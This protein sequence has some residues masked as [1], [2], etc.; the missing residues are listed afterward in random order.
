MKTRLLAWAVAAVILSIAVSCLAQ[1]A[2]PKAADDPYKPVLDRMHAITTI[3]LPDWRVHDSNLPHGEDTNI[4][5]SGWETVRINDKWTSGSRWLRH[6]L[7]VPEQLNGYDLRGARLDLDL[8]LDSDDFIQVAVFVNG[9]MV[10][11]TDE[12]TQLPVTL[13]QNALPGQKFL[14]AV[15]V[16][17]NTIATKIMRAQVVVHA[18]ANRPDPETMRLEI[19]SARP[20][21]D[22]Y[23]EGKPTREQQLDAVVKAISLSA[24]D[25]SDQAA[26]DQSLRD[27]QSRLEALRP[28]IKQFGIRAS[29]NSHI[30]MAWLWPWTETVE[31]V[32]NTFSSVLQL[33]R[34]YPD[35]TFSMG[36]AQT[37][38]WMEEKYTALFREIQ[39]RVKEGRWEIVGG[40]W[41]EPDL[42]MPD[43]ESLVRQLLYGKRYF[44][45]K[46]GVD[47][48]IGWNPDSFGYSWQLPQIYK[49]SGIDTFVTQKLAWN[50]TNKFPYRLFWWQ[51]PDGSRVL[52]YFPH[53]YAN[54]IDPDRMANDLA[55][56]GPA[57]WK[58][59]PGANSLT[60]GKLE[61]MYLFGV[62]DHGGGPTRLDLDNA[63]RWSQPDVVYPQLR[64]GD[65][66]GFFKDLRQNED[67]LKIP[68]WND[69]IYF[70]YHRGV[71]TSQSETKRGNRKSE[72]L[73]LNAEKLAAIDTLFG[74]AY[75][76]S[77]F[78][79]AWKSVLFNQFHDILPGSGIAVNY[80]DA[81]RKFAEVGRIANDSIRESLNDL[82]SRIN[83]P[84]ASVLVFNPLPW[85][86]TE[87]VEFQ[88][89]LPEPLDGIRAHGPDGA[90]MNLE[91]LDNDPKTNRIRLRL[92]ADSIPPL[93]YKVVTFGPGKPYRPDVLLH[94]TPISLE[95]EFVKLAVDPSSGCITSLVRKNKEGL[96]EAFA[97][98]DP[99]EGA[100]ATNQ[101]G[102]PCG[103]LLQVF[104]DKP[105][106]WD[107]WNID[108]D[109]VKQHTDLLQADEV[110]L[111]EN[112]PLRAIIRVKKHYQDSQFVQ[113][114]TM[115][116]GVDRVDVHMTVDWHEKHKLLKVAF[117]LS[118]HS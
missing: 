113:D 13:T 104:V 82:A 44:Q 101:D 7:E 30:D 106:Q 118:V 75:P 53:D 76:Q 40:M 63:L 36:S 105:K 23:E 84:A 71:Q 52:T 48:K 32:R 59:D 90:L 117:P 35:L 3:S 94:A 16:T 103:S 68:T 8:F 88:T 77:N 99:G 57:M 25:R 65:S 98:A 79:T 37:Y 74:A 56:F 51:S 45:Q 87:I 18:A 60:P 100:P 96:I 69:E 42:N 28:Y 73:M 39:Q 111:A 11:R 27:A 38:E 91:V 21:V 55:L 110:T 46:F 43:G 12:D 22:A 66:A 4:S 31:V 86:R 17:A 78:D 97:S 6:T 64:F 34:E 10:S 80:L 50:D 72:V 41:V 24:L 67:E 61:M 33:M 102:K 107:A 19:L 49:R 70:E 14:V 112:T 93:G 5:D 58:P 116:P 95:N 114:I 15:R 20:V 83:T 26:F 89:Q 108:A 62:G 47:V 9:S 115:Y 85:A 29:G 109:F 54:A 2:G 92:S 1:S 81:A